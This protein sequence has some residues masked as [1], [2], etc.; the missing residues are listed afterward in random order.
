MQRLR[1]WFIAGFFLIVPV[2]ASVAALVWIFRVVDGFTSPIYTRLLGRAVPGLGLVTT[3]VA[4]L[5]VGAVASNVIGRRVLQRME[6]WL[7]LVPLFRTVYAPVRQLVLAFSPENEFGFK[8]V[9]LV[10]D[11]QRGYTIGFLTREFTV[12]TGDQTQSLVAVYVPTNHVYLGDVRV[13]PRDRLVFPDLSV[14]EGVRIFLTAG[15][16][17]PSRVE[18]ERPGLQ[19]GPPGV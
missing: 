16:A 19:A 3:V 4:V 1:R 6:H 12:V 9:V 14:E 10:S 17:L 13:Y 11:P 2:V 18:G 7:M 8:Q 5:L 15:M